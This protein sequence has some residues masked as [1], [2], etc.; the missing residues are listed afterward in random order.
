MGRVTG[1]LLPLIILIAIMYFML[2]RP[3]K[4]REREVNAMRSNLHVGDEIITIGGICGKIVKTKEETIV[5][6]VGADKLKFE[7]MRWSVSK[8]IDSVEKK[9]IRR[10]EEVAEAEDF[11]ETEETKARPKRLEKAAPAAEEVEEAPVEEA[12][13]EAEEVAEEAEA[14]AAQK[15]DT[16]VSEVAKEE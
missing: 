12:S 11:E 7:M 8:V 9:D 13:A 6:Q 2:I 15:V 3:Q 5:I 4:K 1:M 10:R 14:E 16:E